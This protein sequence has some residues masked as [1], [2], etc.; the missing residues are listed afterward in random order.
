[1]SDRYDALV[2]GGGPGGSATAYHLAR[3]GARVLLCEK[4][5]YPRDKV[6]GDGLTP[7][8]VAALDAMGLRDEYK[9]WSRS[10]GL[11]G[12]LV[13]VEAVPAGVE[14]SAVPTV[15]VVPRAGT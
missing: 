2:I 12:A 9:D 6:C 8:A 13:A 4:A 7:R 11:T 5:A 3:G 14:L 1:M 10:A 15:P